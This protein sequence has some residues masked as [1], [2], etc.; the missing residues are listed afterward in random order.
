MSNEA[1]Q[2][3][4]SSPETQPAEVR[5]ELEQDLITHQGK[6]AEPAKD[7]SDSQTHMGATEENV[8]PV[9]TP[10]SGAS[11]VTEPDEEEQD[12]NP[13]TELTPG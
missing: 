4:P 9:K 11:K 1:D 7:N 13:Q 10:M 8:T 3:L 6:P 5:E 12:I 2:K